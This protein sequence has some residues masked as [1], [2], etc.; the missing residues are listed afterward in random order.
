MPFFSFSSLLDTLLPFGQTIT[1]HHPFLPP[2]PPFPTHAI[3]SPSLS[4][5]QSPSESLRKLT[6]LFCFHLL[7]SLPMLFTLPLYPCFNLLLRVS[8]KAIIVKLPGESLKIWYIFKVQWF[9]SLLQCV[10]VR[11]FFSRY[12]FESPTSNMSSKVILKLFYLPQVILKLHKY[13]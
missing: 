11:D 3:Y 8:G 4:L 10:L 7:H 12:L 5:F 9:T 2:P 1:S 6:V 13:P